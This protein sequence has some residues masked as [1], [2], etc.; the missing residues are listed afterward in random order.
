MLRSLARQWGL[1]L[2]KSPARFAG[3]A[4]E[5]PF[6]PHQF[7]PA[8]WLGRLIA[9][10]RPSLHGDI[11]SQV[12]VVG[13]ISA[14]VP[15]IFMDVRPLPVRLPGLAP[16]AGDMTRLPFPD[17]SLISL[18]SLNVIGQV[19]L[20]QGSVPADEAAA[21]KGLGE[22]QR[23]LG[24]R[25]SLYLSIPV[26]RERVVNGRRIF[27]PEM[28]LR[29]VPFLRLRRFSYVGDDRMLHADAPLEEA[30]RQNHG[31]GLFEFERG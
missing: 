31:C 20:G 29:V 7:Y 15:V 16:V 6:D 10:S 12:T 14:F 3:P 28:I 9:K 1:P 27:A 8:A 23:V 18:S 21:A 30:A 4:Q 13:A 24:Y 2:V 17:K 19:G 26:G 11:G 22:L 5:T 25:G